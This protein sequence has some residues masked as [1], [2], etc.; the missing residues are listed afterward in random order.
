MQR[1]KT[2]TCNEFQALKIPCMHAIAAATRYKIRIDSLVDQC[3]SRTAYRE[4]YSKII[5]PVV[6]YES[7]EI[8]FSDSSVSELEINPPASRRPPGRPRKNRILS[9]GEFQMRVPKRRTV[10]S[11]C[12]GSGHNR[13]T[14]KVAI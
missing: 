6:E 13:A 11:R 12:K 4:A 3:Y 1:Q 9:R 10:C 7:I 14:C 5:N 2:C 8:L